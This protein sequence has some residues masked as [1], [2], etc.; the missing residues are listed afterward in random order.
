M[1]Y[2]Q[3]MAELVLDHMKLSGTTVIRGE[4]PH[5]VTQHDADSEI[6]V[7][8]GSGADVYD[9]V[10]LAV[11][12]YKSQNNNLVSIKGTFHLHVP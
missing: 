1:I 9:T 2:L 8:W 4:T 6:L 12:K 7:E 10:L 5:R 11:G 3:Q